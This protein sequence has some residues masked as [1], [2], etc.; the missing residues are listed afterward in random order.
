MYACTIRV[1]HLPMLLTLNFPN[2][3]VSMYMY[4]PYGGGG[5][6]ARVEQ[7]VNGLEQRVNK[8]CNIL[9]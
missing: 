8:R 3:C 1:Y 5:P 7:K 9:F 6:A 2:L 4:V